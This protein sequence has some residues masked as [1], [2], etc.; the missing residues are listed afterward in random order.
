[1]IRK[2]QS[3]LKAKHRSALPQVLIASSECAPLSKTGGLADVAGALPKS[4]AK[5]GFDA[6][7]ITPYH[8]CIK[9]K[10]ADKTEHICDFTL[11]LGWRRQYV[12]IEKLVVD[13]VTFYLVDNEYYFHHDS[14]Y[15]GGS[16]EIEQFAYFSRAVLE[17]LPYL[18]FEPEILHCNDWQCAM[19]P[20]LIKTQYADKPQGKLK[21]L[22]TIHNMAFQG[23]TDF[24]FLSNLLDIDS[25]YMTIDCLEFYGR[26]NM[27]KAGLYYADRVNT[28]SPTY[29]QELRTEE[30]GAG[31]HGVIN[32]ISDKLSGIINGLDYKVFNPWTDS[33]IP[34][35][36]SAAKLNGKTKCRRA[37]CKEFSLD[38]SDD[39]PIF[40]M[41]T[42]MTDQKG[43]DLVIQVLERMV[44]MGAAFILL[45]SGDKNY[46]YAIKDAQ[47]RHKG[48]IVAHIGYN[49]ELAN[50]IYAASDFYLMPSKFEP[51]GL[52]QMIAMRYGSIPVVRSTGG[53]H[54]TVIPFDGT[55][56][57]GF[58]FDGYDATALLKSIGDAIKVYQDKNQMNTLVHNAMTTDFSFAVSAETYADLY[59]EMI[60]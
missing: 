29:A 38:V 44:E 8:K 50:K 33:L 53:L 13:G 35:R 60:E 36:Y 56:G 3:I 10:Y 14:L 21:T 43:F 12:G 20:M 52:S 6:R 22:L 55:H 42:R 32:E 30:F 27:M 51:C 59:L 5:L 47:Y 58:V 25:K 40:A 16:A 18:D 7:V 49:A 15:L 1:M 28:V 57:T 11:S 46:E 17:S 9:E 2:H 39:T 24:A 41:V 45:G 31:L 54:D 37:L 26:A 23:I 48:K 34:Y 4:F 19:I